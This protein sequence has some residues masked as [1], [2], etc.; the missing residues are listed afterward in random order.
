MW[1]QSDITWYSVL[2]VFGLCLARS[3]MLCD[4]AI[5]NSSG[6]RNRRFIVFS[7]DGVPEYEGV[8]VD[9]V[10]SDYDGPYDYD[11]WYDDVDVDDDYD[12]SNGPGYHHVWWHHFYHHDEPHLPF[13]LFPPIVV[14]RLQPFYRGCDQW[15]FE[16]RNILE[17]VRW[18]QCYYEFIDKTHI[19]DYAVGVHTWKK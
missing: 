2:M 9:D 12:H 7:G 17:A 11:D 5:A 8:D 15:P 14:H 19:N 18:L 6:P 13:P 1:F 10:P 16:C 3:G 4:D